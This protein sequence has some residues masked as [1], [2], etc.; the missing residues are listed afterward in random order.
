MSQ[1]LRRGLPLLV[2]GAV[3]LAGLSFAA[4]SGEEPSGQGEPPVRLKKKRPAPRAEE[5]EPPRPAPA[6]PPARKKEAPDEEK[7]KEDRLKKEGDKGPEPGEP[8]P[9]EKEVLDRVVKNMRAVEK[10]LGDR[11]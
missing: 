5:P 10:K 4:V 11:A 1:C 7:G 3:L 9:D 6:T 2:T 8:E